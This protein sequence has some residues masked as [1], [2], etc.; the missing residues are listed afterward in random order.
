MWQRREYKYLLTAD[1]Y[2]QLSRY[3]QSR[4][5]KPD[6]YS[7]GTKNNS[8]YVA[9]LYLDTPDYQ[10]YWDKQY[11]VKIR[12]K[13]RLRTYEHRGTAS[14]PIYWEIKK[15]YGDFF[16]KNRTAKSWS[17]TKQWLAGRLGLSRLGE[18]ADFYL[19]VATKNLQPLLLISYWREPWL[20]PKHPDLRL[21]FDSNI[22]AAPT[23]DLFSRHR[24]ADVFPNQY[25]LEI[26]FSGPVPGY[27]V[28]FCRLN[29]LSRQSLS[30][31]CRGLEACGIVS[32][33]NL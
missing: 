5:L 12:T 8:Y 1:Q 19:A 23:A 28:E 25:I 9:S 6:K 3:L 30:K 11:G 31:Y 14:T 18:V 21:T 27:V 16:K 24:L 33:E 17:K 4:G 26:K 7:A 10:A 13:Y 2:R 22:Q 20:D 32:E 15:K 29:S